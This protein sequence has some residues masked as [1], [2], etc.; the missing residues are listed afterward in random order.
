MDLECEH[1]GQSKTFSTLGG[2]AFI[3]LADLLFLFPILQI[4]ND[5]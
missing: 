2:A 1:L 5:I 4:N 3:I